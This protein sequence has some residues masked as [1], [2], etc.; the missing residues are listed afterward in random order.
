MHQTQYDCCVVGG[1]MIGAAVALGLARQSYKVA[2]VEKQALVPFDADQLPDIRLS[3]LNMHSVSLLTALGAWQH[4]E[5]MRYRAYDTLS[6]WD[7]EDVSLGV[8]ASAL[9]GIGVNNRTRT[10]FT[11]QEV[12]QSLLGYF[13]E[14]RLIQVALFDEIK[15]NY[16]HLID[17]IHE[18]EINSIDVKQG[19][20]T[21]N[22]E[23]SINARLIIG[24]DGAN[25][26]VRKAAEIATSGWQYSQQA[27][28]IL[29]RTATKVPD[30][31][32]QAFHKTGPRALLPMYD[33][34]ACLV[35][36]DNAVKSEQI[37]RSSK[38]ELSKEIK[39]NFPDLTQEFEIIKVAGFSLTRMHANT[40]G[41]GRA[42]LAGDAAHTINPLAGQGVNLG[43]QD[44][45][46][47]LDVI[48]QHGLDNS[49]E[50]I[51]SYERKRKVPNLVMMSAMDLLYKSFSTS[52]L[53]I[54]IARK[55]G[56]ALANNAGPLKQK[57]L[58]YAMG[59]EK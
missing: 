6:V 45:S 50:L 28:A 51:A 10:Q 57:A 9:S 55:L 31:T 20:V 4:I 56:L 25:S 14:N 7:A 41:K 8:V 15:F 33:N 35:W 29:I 24:A 46:A 40:Y 37:K 18:Q 59:L 30:E 13:V 36:Y 54:S 58:K 1:G 34:Y 2:L 49:R 17:C 19:I 12:G 53:P 42:I 43:F 5:N 22:N 52:A 26:R 21:L 47:L 16:H 44:V 32:W 39:Q 27:N 11:A 23:Q 38:D 48:E 3:A